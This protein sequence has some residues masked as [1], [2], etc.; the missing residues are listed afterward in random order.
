[1]EFGP[2]PSE[3]LVAS[4]FQGS[5]GVLILRRTDEGRDLEIVARNRDIPTRTSFVWL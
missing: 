1:M 5:G 4:G 3:F 2:D